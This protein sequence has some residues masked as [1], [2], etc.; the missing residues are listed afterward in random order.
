[1]AKS[2]LKFAL[3]LCIFLAGFWSFC[4]SLNDDTKLQPTADF[5]PM[6]NGNNQ[7]EFLKYYHFSDVP[8]F[9]SL[10]QDKRSTR[11]HV[12][13]GG[14]KTRKILQ[15]IGNLHCV[16]CLHVGCSSSPSCP[17]NCCIY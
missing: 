9:P 11:V 1:M 3:L 2:G 17:A 15:T 10:I 14:I 5:V 7:Q 12:T 8:N 13:S 4:L 6:K 16:G